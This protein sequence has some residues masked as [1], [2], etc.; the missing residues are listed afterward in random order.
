MSS[1]SA[2][3]KTAAKRLLRPLSTRVRARLGPR[4][5]P[6]EARL[7]ALENGWRQ[8]LPGLLN[9]VSSIAAFGYELA[10]LRR[11]MQA[12]ADGS[13]EAIAALRGEM[14]AKADESRGAVVTLQRE[15]ETFGR[16]QR[17]ATDRVATEISNLWKSADLSTRG[18]GD[19]W[20]RVE[21][22]RREIMYESKYGLTNKSTTEKSARILSPE[23][24][25]KARAT[26]AR[27]NL[28][29]GHIPLDGYI[30]VDQR[31]LPGVDI[32]T[33]VGNLPFEERSV[34]E[35]FSAH[36]L[37]HLPQERLRRLLPYWHSL[38]KT[39]GIFRA[40]VP[41]GEAMLAGIAAGT[42][43]FEN[44]REVLFGAQEYEGD[45]HFNLLTSDSFAKLLQE[46][47]FRGIKVPVK[48]RQ[49]NI[50]F[51]FEIVAIK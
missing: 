51:E 31:K 35:I 28:G 16:D 43:S 21:F 44:F 27:L 7:A 41:D 25:E 18:I 9:A 38:L 5:Q 24:V 46:S 14:Q 45:F 36:V 20:Q 3:L 32:V 8:H 2:S 29:C 4:L 49:N 13:S 6:I 12:N 37:E 19:L 22:V 50:C 39:E 17:A 48:G 10:S 11:E 47:G 33:D 26:G 40:V 15:F 1:I 42:Y 34:S 23:K 30:N